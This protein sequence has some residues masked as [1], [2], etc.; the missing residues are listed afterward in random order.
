MCAVRN[1]CRFLAIAGLVVSLIVAEVCMA[2]IIV[3]GETTP[4]YYPGLSFTTLACLVW[5]VKYSE[6]DR[7]NQTGA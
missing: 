7:P 4:P 3:L 2:V 5:I 6:K 1:P